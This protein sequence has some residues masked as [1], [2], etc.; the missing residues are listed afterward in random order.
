M[1]RFIQS[2]TELF[3][4][5]LRSLAVLRL[6]IG[7]LLLHD[8]VQRSGDLVAHYT[9]FGVLP[10]TAMIQNT[11]SRWVVSIHL[12]SGTWEVEAI[13]FVTVA[14]FAVL[15]LPWA[16]PTAPATVSLLGT[17]HSDCAPGQMP[18]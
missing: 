17:F 7:L 3:E 14:L 8:L 13:L 15:W 11:Y 1:V 4:T 10:R 16:L 18:F 5:D 6:G 2:V 12:M 9:N